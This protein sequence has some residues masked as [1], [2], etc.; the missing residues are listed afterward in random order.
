MI[1]L[2]VKRRW[3]LNQSPTD[4]PDDSQSPA[5]GSDQQGGEQNNQGN[6]NKNEKKRKV[7]KQGK[8]GEGSDG[9]AEQD[10]AKQEA[11]SKGQGKP[12]KKG[13]SKP[14]SKSRPRSNQK[15]KGSDDSG[16]EENE[17]DSDST[18]GEGKNAVNAFDLQTQEKRKRLANSFANIMAKLAEEPL[19]S[20]IYGDERY[21]MKDLML[22]HITRKPLSQ[23]RESRQKVGCVLVVDSSPSCKHMREI[24]PI[25]A[26]QAAACN[27]LEVYDAPNAEIQRKWCP[28]QKKWV[29]CKL[30]VFSRRRI[31]FCG[32][33]DGSEILIEWA[34]KKNLVYWF[35]CAPDAVKESPTDPRKARRDRFVS[36]G[37]CYFW[38]SRTE[39]DLVR[40]AKCI[41]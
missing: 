34:K 38:P 1:K 23:C 22:R 6:A 14:N 16:D 15:N 11:S 19:G 17:E 30:P 28:K 32:D 35:S 26:R 8:D 3:R 24:Y 27:D 7:G 20:P 36:A 37:G 21:S 41:R 5:S 18:D 40:L 25:I 31:I 29:N 9:S 33:F 4:T 13:E 2:Q 10:E 12:Q 39:E